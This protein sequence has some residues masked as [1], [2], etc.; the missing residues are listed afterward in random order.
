MYIIIEMWF[1]MPGFTISVVLIS[2]NF[3]LCNLSSQIYNGV[4]YIFF[5][6]RAVRDLQ[7]DLRDGVLLSRIIEAVCE[8]YLN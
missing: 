3:I 4:F 2:I 1:S 6:L 7:A 5:N 8:F